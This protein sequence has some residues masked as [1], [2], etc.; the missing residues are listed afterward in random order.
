MTV[1]SIITFASSKGGVGKSTACAAV[2]GALCKKGYAVT[3]IDVDQ[4]L[5]LHRWFTTHKPAIA[6]LSVIATNPQ[7]FTRTVDAAAE[8]GADFV[9]IDIAG[10]Y[11]ATVIKAIRASTLVISPARLSE[12]DLREAGRILLEVHAFNKQFKVAIQHRLLVNDAEHIDPQYQ[13][14]SLAKLDNSALKRIANLMYKRVAYRE[15]FLSGLPPH[16]AEQSREAIRN[17]VKEL[18]LITDEILALAGI[19]QASPPETN[20]EAAA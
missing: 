20:L 3:V 8:S 6:G 1:R 17:A 7:D 4:N 13:R 5:T 12:P 18:D 2:A 14:L 11:E 9:L 10:S 15:I 16:Y 19:H